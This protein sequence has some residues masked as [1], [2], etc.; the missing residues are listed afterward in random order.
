MET[1]RS[2]AFSTE[3][4]SSDCLGCASAAD[5]AGPINATSRR[6]TEHVATDRPVPDQ[7]RSLSA[8]AIA[9]R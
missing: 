4:Y 6:S 3:P 9:A 1:P 8:A 2:S 5:V 7:K